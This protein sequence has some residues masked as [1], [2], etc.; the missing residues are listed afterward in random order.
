M[1]TTR[2]DAETLFPTATGKE[3]SFLE[4]A[5]KSTLPDPY[6]QF[7]LEHNGLFIPGGVWV[8]S[9]KR[10]FVITYVYGI[11]YEDERG[12]ILSELQAYYFNQRVP[13][14][15][16]PIA[17]CQSFERVVLCVDGANKGKVYYWKPP[18]AW[19]EKQVITEEYLSEIAESFTTFWKLLNWDAEVE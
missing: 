10:P 7:L 9:P 17:D 1:F 18:D 15:F 16:I 8:D 14:N 4:D 5:T 12:N 11:S 19:Q 3:L 6:R 13:A 2:Q